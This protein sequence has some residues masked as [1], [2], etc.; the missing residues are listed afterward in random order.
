VIVAIVNRKAILSCK[1]FNSRPREDE[2][3]MMWIEAK[4]FVALLFYQFLWSHGDDFLGI[5]NGSQVC[6]PQI[7]TLPN[8]TN[9][10][11]YRV[12]VLAIRGE[13]AA[14]AEFNKTFSEYLTMTAGQRFDRT[15]TFKMVPLDFIRLFS[16]VELATETNGAE[17]VDFIYVN[18]SAF[19][20]IESEYGANTLVS[21]VSR[22]VVEDKVYLLT[23]FGGVIFA[24]ADNDEINEIEDIRGKI[25]A[26]ADISGLGSGQMQFRLL[27]Q[28]GV[29]Y[30]QDPKQIIFTA[31]QNLV[32]IGVLEGK[33]DVGFV[34]TDQIERTVNNVTGELIDKTKLKII[35]GAFPML[36]GEA[37]PFESS[38]IL[39][40]EWNVGSLSHV[41]NAVAVEVQAALLAIRDHG[42]VGETLDSCYVASNCTDA[43][44]GIFNPTDPCFSACVAQFELEGVVANRC[45]TT[46]KLA[47]TAIA[48]ERKGKYTG[49][50]STLSYMELRNMQEET[51]FIRKQ[52]NGTMSCIR[53]ERI[54][55]A[56]V[57]PPGHFRK[58][59][60]Q[61]LLG[62]AD[63]GLDCGGFLCL[64]KPC[65]KSFDVDVFPRDKVNEADGSSGPCPKFA[66]CGR[67]I[68]GQK[69]TFRAVDNKD[70]ADPEFSAIVLEGANERKLEVKRIPTANNTVEFTFDSIGSVIGVVIFQVFVD[71]EQIPE[72]PFRLMVD[73]RQCAKET[74]DSL[75]VVDEDGTCVCSPG[76]ND[77]GGKCVSNNVLVPS[78]VIPLVVLL[79]VA[80]YA[81]IE[82]RNKKADSVWTVK[83]EELVFDDP[84][85]ILGRGTFGLVLLAEYRGTQVAVKRVIPPR[86]RKGKEGA[87]Y[88]TWRN[89]FLGSTD[90][91]EFDEI[92]EQR[93]DIQ[94]EFNEADLDEYHTESHDLDAMESGAVSPSRR[95]TD[96]RCVVETS[97]SSSVATGTAS[98]KRK[99]RASLGSMNKTDEYFDF[100]NLDKIQPEADF[101]RS[102]AYRRHSINT[103]GTGF[104]TLEPTIVEGEDFGTTMMKRRDSGGSLPETDSAL[105]EV[106]GYQ[107]Q[108]MPR[109]HST[110]GGYPGTFTAAPLMATPLS[111]TIRTT[112]GASVQ[113]DEG[114]LSRR[115]S[116]ASF[117]S[118]NFAE[119]RKMIEEEE[120]KE[121]ALNSCYV[122]SGSDSFGQFL[123]SRR[124]M[125]ISTDLHS[126]TSAS[127]GKVF[128]FKTI[129]KSLFG[130]G[131]EYSRLKKDFIAEMRHLSKLRHPC[132]TTVMG[133]VIS[134]KF[135]PMLV[136]E[137]MD[138]GSLYDILHNDSMIIDGEV[139]LPILRDIAQ[140][141]RFL[142]AASPKV[143]HGDLKAQNV[144]VG[145]YTFSLI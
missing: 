61:V 119:F 26:C 87:K 62:C 95:T 24:R 140:G 44:N 104:T 8:S 64:C 35:N 84:P 121:T 114:S 59:D 43:L 41:P 13:E 130:S 110:G 32:V 49:F 50:R 77:I 116:E 42:Q 7:R 139:V 75:R 68:Q 16:D 100:K 9:K 58:S 86:V 120:K 137:Y 122:K 85:A 23:K 98:A 141:V 76:S 56:V 60:E 71:S 93:Q 70:R 47:S 123:Q 30:L 27:E 80:V 36:D 65:V 109:R 143:I 39:Y 11:E 5:N 74:G 34:R 89:S 126:R 78:L 125:A 99:R 82:Y 88:S 113:S 142:H 1:S 108:R 31:D 37:F 15:L 118:V 57:C 48:A 33:Y 21:Q 10:T 112:S 135:E 17:G 52:E 105:R 103:A 51:N 38:T 40:P 66:I 134:T 96:A 138:H 79:G 4:L 3:I 128:G 54:V 101:R 53:S 136:M 6:L 117:N 72:S 63:A 90:D 144:L 19:S 106:A 25:V 69:V 145:E 73:A 22:R 29:A 67:V 111:G 92:P 131:D 132:I 14:Y 124:N 115:G 81:Y 28:K 97:D 83:P 129:S 94:L 12:G 20:C 107:A 18:P 91:I 45:D 102:R 46:P 127:G 2:A 55:D 133:A